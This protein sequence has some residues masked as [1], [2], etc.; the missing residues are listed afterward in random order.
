[1]K[2]KCKQILTDNLDDIDNN[3]VQESV[4]LTNVRKKSGR[5]GEDELDS[6]DLL[7]TE[8]TKGTDESPSVSGDEQEV[9][10]PGSV[11]L[12]VGFGFPS[13]NENAQFGLGIEVLVV[14]VDGFESSEGFVI[15]ALLSEPSGRLG[16][17]EQADA[18]SEGNDNV[19]CDGE[20]PRKGA[21][22]V[23]GSL[24]DTSTDDLRRA[25]WSAFSAQYVWRV[26]APPE[27]SPD[28]WLKSIA[29]SRRWN[30][31]WR[32]EESRTGTWAHSSRRYRHRYRGSID[33]R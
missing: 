12:I 33:Q 21:L 11:A 16:Y 18:D 26:P 30:H 22:V 28:R 24:S 4:G 20:S 14:L 27:H 1:V 10:P 5:V 31:E 15:L 25:L 8:D 13:G 17:E 3:G 7:T 6:R 32:Q 23:F 2:P 29:R 19:E 9:L